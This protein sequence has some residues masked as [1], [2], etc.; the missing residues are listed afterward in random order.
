M[1]ADDDAVFANQNGVELDDGVDL[2]PTPRA[3]ARS[4]KL[5]RPNKKEVLGEVSK[6]TPFD[7]PLGRLGKLRQKYSKKEELGS[8]P[9]PPQHNF[10][11]R[12]VS[13]AA[14]TKHEAARYSSRLK[15][16]NSEKQKDK[17]KHRVAFDKS[18][19][20]TSNGG[21]GNWISKLFFDK[22]KQN[23]KRR[24]HPTDPDASKIFLKFIRKSFIGNY[25]PASEASRGV[26]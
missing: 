25:P 13:V 24:R 9:N 3:R 7:W 4:E 2:P 15:R 12:S 5:F 21:A 20:T 18:Y 11:V 17:Q 22:S 1:K 10:T 14:L 23:K 19:S 16:N 8:S 26:Y 6:K